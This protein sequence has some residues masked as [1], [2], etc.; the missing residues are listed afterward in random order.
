M[1]RWPAQVRWRQNVGH[2][3][4]RPAG[5]SGNVSFHHRPR[6]QTPVGQRAGPVLHQLQ[7]GGDHRALE[8]AAARVHQRGPGQQAVPEGECRQYSDVNAFADANV[9]LP[10]NNDRFARTRSPSAEGQPRRFRLPPHGPPARAQLHRVLGPEHE[11]AARGALRE[12]AV[13]RAEGFGHRDHKLAAH[14]ARVAA[15]AAQE[16]TAQ[17]VHHGQLHR[18]HHR[19][20]FHKTR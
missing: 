17:R 6:G 15:G 14:R 4:A 3:V 2:G 18:R 5:Q 8:H 1:I 12:N 10:M 19:L 13:G 20:G 16:G 9:N 11:D 7:R